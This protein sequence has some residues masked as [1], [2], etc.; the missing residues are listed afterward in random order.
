MQ[1]SNSQECCI[2]DL[3]IRPE[4]T[5]RPKGPQL[6]RGNRS[7][8]KQPRQPKGEE[9]ERV[10]QTELARRPLKAGRAKSELVRRLFTGV[11]GDPTR[12]IGHDT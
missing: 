12:R 5:Q 11:V 9:G 8:S 7:A 2:Q 3:S 10:G 6:P 4:W 1:V